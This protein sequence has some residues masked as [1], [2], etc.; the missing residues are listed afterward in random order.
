MV[1]HR[2]SRC[3]GCYYASVLVVKRIGARMKGF[4]EIDTMINI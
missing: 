3:I 1:V 4:Y 2:F